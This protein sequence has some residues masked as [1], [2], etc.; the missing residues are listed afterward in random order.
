MNVNDALEN[1]TL[2]RVHA[3]EICNGK[4]TDEEND[5][6]RQV[7]DA[8]GII[9]VGGSDAHSKEAVGTCVTNFEAQSERTGFDHS[10]YES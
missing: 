9:K 1:P 6:A 8:L 3:L 10:H 2:S 5:F 4:V 7:A